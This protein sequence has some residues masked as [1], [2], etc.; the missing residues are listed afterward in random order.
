MAKKSKS[1]D[2]A[3][4]DVSGDK[5]VK[6]KK[7][8]KSKELAE[9]KAFSPYAHL[10]SEID[11]MEKKFGLTSMAVSESEDRL[12]TGLLSIDVNLAGGLLPGG[13]YTF[14]GGE[15]SCKST[16][17]TTAMGSIATNAAFQGIGA[18]FDYEGSFQADY[19]ENIFKYM[20]HGKRISVDNVFGVKDD[21]GWVIEPRVRY[22]APS[23][24]EDFYN[25]LAKLEKLLPD[26]IQENG[27][28]YYVYENT[29]VN[30]KA[31]AGKYDKEYFRRENKFRLP[32]PNGMPQAVI[33][34][35]SYPAMVPKQTD[36]KEEGDKSLGSQARMHAANLPRVKGAMRG[37][38][39]IVLGINQLRDIPMA[40]YGPTEQE[41]GGKALRFYSDC[42]LK[43]TSVSV[44][45]AKGQFEE[46]DTIS[47]EGADKY[48]YLKCKVQKNKLGGPQAA[49]I[50]LRIRVSDADGNASGFCRVWD[51]YQYLKMT[52]QLGGNR[53]KLKFL[54]GPLAGITVPWINFKALV[55][56]DAAMIKK[57]CEKM[58]VKPFRLYEWCRKQVID[59][60]A[61]QMLKANIK[62][63]NTK[64]KQPAEIAEGADEE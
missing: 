59:K 25:Y 45:H 47:G 27:K 39:I 20:N 22:Y 60:T 31:L 11:S 2:V 18:M 37:K 54:T 32:A 43:M 48:R 56:G 55:D 34:V 16:L 28:F 44:P 53:K 35:D 36:D 26:L 4:I 1:K 49:E 14:F 19:A 46:E 10:G 33:L 40:M 7:G 3:V 13:W 21:K 8:K 50:S 9:P 12:S 52:G 41:P 38:R 23:V 58:K 15:Q 63:E 29:K 6:G 24:G 62:A 42:R 30:Q 57:G 5:P 64:S 51:C 17:A 61:Y